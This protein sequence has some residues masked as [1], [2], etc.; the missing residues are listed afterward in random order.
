MSGEYSQLAGCNVLIVDAD[1]EVSSLLSDIFAASGAIVTSCYD[2]H[3]AMLDLQTRPFDLVIL[4]VVLPG[5]GGWDV[6]TF[7]QKIC[8]AMLRRTVLLTADR[9]TAQAI[10]T[11]RFVTGPIVYKPF[12]VEELRAAAAEAMTNLHETDAA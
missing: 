2:G 12:D 4:D 7:M 6:L 9:Q 10:Q 11:S 5:I 8:P 1:P 3:A